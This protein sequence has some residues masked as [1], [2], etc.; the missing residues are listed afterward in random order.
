MNYD[1]LEKKKIYI[2]NKIK[3]SN[4]NYNIILF[5]YYSYMCQSLWKH[6]LL[7]ELDPDTVSDAL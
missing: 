6:R 2:W 1:E 3:I 7:Q 5:L 4:P